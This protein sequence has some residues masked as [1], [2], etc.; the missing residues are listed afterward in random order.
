M[1]KFLFL[2][3]FCFNSLGAN[4]WISFDDIDP[5]SKETLLFWDDTNSM[6]QYG[7]MADISFFYSYMYGIKLNLTHWMKLP[8]PPIKNVLIG[9][10]IDFYPR[11]PARP[12]P[13]D[14]RDIC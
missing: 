1:K 10:Y 3:L 12:K 13:N 7:S 4:E 11:D 2:I 6:I 9:L 14:I 5:D 8:N